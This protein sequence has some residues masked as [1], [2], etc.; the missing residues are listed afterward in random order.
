LSAN[1]TLAVFDD[2][3]LTNL[4]LPWL[5][6]PYIW[7]SRNTAWIGLIRSWWIWSDAAVDTPVDVLY[8]KFIM[9]DQGTYDPVPSYNP[10]AAPSSVH[11][12]ALAS[13]TGYWLAVDCYQW[14]QVVCQTVTTM[15]PRT[16][17]TVSSEEQLTTTSGQNS[18]KS[19]G[20]LSSNNAAMIAAIVLGTLLGLGLIITAVFVVLWVKSQRKL[21]K[22]EQRSSDGNVNSAAVPVTLHGHRQSNDDVSS[23]YQMTDASSWAQPSMYEELQQQKQQ[24]R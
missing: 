17:W 22:I 5:D 21:E 11:Y 4:A 2:D 20:T 19:V 18:S 8:N 1:G 7:T 3:F 23:P 13:A 24:R 10:P 6:S 14:R 9:P 16:V 12:C 15:K